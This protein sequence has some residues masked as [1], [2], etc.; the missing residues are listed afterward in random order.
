MR[1]W[2]LPLLFLGLLLAA[3]GGSSASPTPA[4]TEDPFGPPPSLGGNVV[5]VTPP[6]RARVPQAETRR[7]TL[8]A[9]GGVCA[10]ASF[11]GLPER[12]LWFR[13]AVDGVEVTDRLVWYLSSQNAAEGVVCFQPQEGLSVGLH[14]AAVAVQNPFNLNEPPRQLV[15]WSFEVTP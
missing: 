5:E 10:R 1:R 3:C 6:H 13:M 11:A 12:T 4:P 14:N 7:G 8:Q 15:A 9:P 2:F